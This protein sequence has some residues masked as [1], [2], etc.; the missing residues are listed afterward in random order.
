MKK[1]ENISLKKIHRLCLVNKKM[2]MSLSFTE[3][4]IDSQIKK[5]EEVLKATPEILET[6]DEVCEKCGKPMVVKVGRF[7]KFLACSGFPECKST[8]KLITAENSFGACPECKEGSV[9]MRRTKTRR[10]FYGCS[11]YPECK[12]ASWTKPGVE[13]KD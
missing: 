7:G 12:H 5:Y 10:F 11:R 2:L 3:K 8:K 6:T 9:I 13:L 1:N 4:E